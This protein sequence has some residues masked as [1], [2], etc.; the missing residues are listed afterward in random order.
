MQFQLELSGPC[1]RA[2]STDY[3][4]VSGLFLRVL[5]P[6]SRFVNFNGQAAS[7]DSLP[8]MKS[9][10]NSLDNGENASSAKN[11]RE[12]SKL[13]KIEKFR[14]VASSVGSQGGW[15]K[16]LQTKIA[17]EHSSQ[18]SGQTDVSLSFNAN[19]EHIF[20]FYC[21]SYILRGVIHG[22]CDS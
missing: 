18:I 9:S 20:M 11:D 4:V 15:T 5:C 3:D 21:K 7:M 2:I 16:A 22:F 13:S 19:G 12:K 14:R 1:A 6:Y 10:G 17:D 8:N